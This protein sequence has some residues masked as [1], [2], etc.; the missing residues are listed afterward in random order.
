[1]VEGLS[2]W[3]R[4]SEKAWPLILADV[5]PLG[6][7]PLGLTVF[8]ASSALALSK[9]NNSRSPDHVIASCDTLAL[10]EADVLV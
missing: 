5:R 7:L 9:A 4:V 10:P 3:S 1:M 2:F 6:F 8:Q